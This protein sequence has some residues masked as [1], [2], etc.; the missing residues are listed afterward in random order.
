MMAQA[1]SA[2]SESQF[3]PCGVTLMGDP[4][5]SDGLCGVC[6]GA[7]HESECPCDACE[8]YWSGIT[9]ESAAAAE[10]FN[11]R[12]VCMCGWTGPFPEHHRE[13]QPGCEINLRDGG[14]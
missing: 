13:K 10:E 3:C 2:L 4:D 14:A 11:R 1:D 7:P 5:E 12:L 9:R 6:A 8:E